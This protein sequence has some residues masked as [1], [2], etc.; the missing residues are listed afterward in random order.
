MGVV[1]YAFL[2]E[3]DTWSRLDAQDYLSPLLHDR[4]AEPGGPPYWGRLARLAPV[5]RVLVAVR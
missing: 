1:E 5:A 2:R 3:R 4:P